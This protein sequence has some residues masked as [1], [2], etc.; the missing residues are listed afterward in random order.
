MTGYEV[1]A[2]TAIAANFVGC[3]IWLKKSRQLS[4]EHEIYEKANNLFNSAFASAYKDSGAAMLRENTRWTAQTIHQAHHTDQ[5]G[6]FEECPKSTCQAATSLLSSTSDAENK[7][8]NT[9]RV[10]HRFASKI[11]VANTAPKTL[12]GQIAKKQGRTN[13]VR[14]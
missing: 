7:H 2:V 8:A 3:A 10:T 12:L 9:V 11:D 5:P 4:A 1:L 14:E 6:T 13:G